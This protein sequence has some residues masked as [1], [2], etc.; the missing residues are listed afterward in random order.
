M[1]A[2]PLLRLSAADPVK[3]PP[4]VESPER[5][6][7]L[8][9]QE[10]PVTQG[11]R[12]PKARRAAGRRMLIG[13]LL[14]SGICFALLLIDGGSSSPGVNVGAEAYA[15]ITPQ[16]GIVEA[17]FVAHSFGPEGSETLRQQE[18]QDSATRQTRE[19]D[20]LSEPDRVPPRTVLTDWSQS[21]RVSEEWGGT[22]P[23]RSIRRERIPAGARFLLVVKLQ[24]QTRRLVEHIAFAGIGMYG[25]E[26]LDLFRDLYRKGWMRLAGRERRGGRS[27]WKLESRPIHGLSRATR[28][29]LTRLVV[30][31]DPASFLPVLERQ[32]SYAHP[33]HPRVVVENELVR[34]RTISSHSAAIFDLAVQHKGAHVVMRKAKLPTF[35]A[36]HPKD[37]RVQ[38]SH[39]TR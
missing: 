26:S 7:C 36:L 16:R 12:G 31:V 15:A 39:R 3:A 17:V 20:T 24:H 11:W 37:E 33:G 28:G 8:I 25:I 22:V 9:E 5:L 4:E 29:A 21:P 32:I 14:A 10:S 2:D 34:Y 1:K 30:L 6:R 19:L 35:V 18:W 27:L 13:S 23:S 38:A